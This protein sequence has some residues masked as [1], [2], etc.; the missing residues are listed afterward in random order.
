MY[1]FGSNLGPLAQGHLEPWE[2]HLN[3]IG[4]R[5]L[6]NAT[7]QFQASE[8]SDSEEEDFL[9]I[10]YAFLWFGPRTLWPRTILDPGTIVWTNL[11]KGHQTML[12]NKFQAFK[13]SSSGEE[14]F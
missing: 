3:K 6:G 10:F 4:K 11:V 2:L 9:N 1:F 13:P 14:D 5:P 8:P 7:Y 12:H